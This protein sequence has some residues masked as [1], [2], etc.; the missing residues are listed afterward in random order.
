MIQL[1]V[2]T[3]LAFVFIISY[4]NLIHG[5]ICH[6]TVKNANN[7]LISLITNVIRVNKYHYQ[8]NGVI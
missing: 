1:L 6:Q 5:T 2:A 4:N 3:L 8:N 7:N